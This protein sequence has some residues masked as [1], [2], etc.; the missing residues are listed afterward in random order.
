VSN[1]GIV[2]HAQILIRTVSLMLLLVSMS[3][4]D[5]HA[6]YILDAHWDFDGPGTAVTATDVSGNGHHGTVF[7]CAPAPGCSGL[8]N[9][10]LAFFGRGSYV[11]VPSSLDFCTNEW[12]IYALVKINRFSTD[13]SACEWSTILSH[14]NP[15]GS[16]TYYSI[17][18][19]DDPTDGSCSTITPGGNVLCASLDGSSTVPFGKGVPVTTGK[20][21]CFT[22]VN[23]PAGATHQVELYINGALVN[24]YSWPSTGGPCPPLDLLIG[25]GTYGTNDTWFDGVIDDI[26]IYTNAMTPADVAAY[27]TCPPCD[28]TTSGGGGG[29]GPGGPSGPGPTPPCITDIQYNGTLSSPF[30]RSFIATV[31]PSYYW[32]NWYVNGTL[33]STLPSTSPF[34]YNFVT[35]STYTVC[36]ESYDPITS[37]VCDQQC[38]DVCIS[39]TGYKQAPT[40]GGNNGPTKVPGTPK[41]GIGDVYPNPAS[42]LLNIPVHG[43]AGEAEISIS[44]ADGRKMINRHYT[45]KTGE[46]NIAIGIKELPQGTYF[47]QIALGA[48]SIQR[49]FTKL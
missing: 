22:A 14:D 41:N 13:R 46:S 35:S 29:T 47:V 23:R 38:M 32:V 37:V 11:R 34:T 16:G 10:A 43:Y 17:D 40:S 25:R 27:F 20:W 18:V 3:I 48:Q 36:A 5:A 12:T 9:T 7:G 42:T 28:T 31:T 8:P 2:A 4:S 33:I 39:N 19:G 1:Q 30:I 49:T 26:Q 24:S 21:Y 6:Q 15:R 44:T 45:L